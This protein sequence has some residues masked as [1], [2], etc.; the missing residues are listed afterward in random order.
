MNV[1]LRPDLEK[2]VN[3]KIQSGQYRSPDEAL[4]EA[5][6]LLKARDEAEHRLETLLQEA[7][8]SGPATEMTSQ[9]WTDI[10]QDGLR[11]LNSR[12]TA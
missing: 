7:E 1:S 3:E 9:D 10:E 11:R 2:F 12:K 6:N 4:N 5:L 8:D